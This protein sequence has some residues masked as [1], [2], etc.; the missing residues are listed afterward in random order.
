MKQK[1]I[2]AYLCAVM[3]LTMTG[4]GNMDEGQSVNAA[5]TD[6]QVEEDTGEDL[7]HQQKEAGESGGSPAGSADSSEDIV[8]EEP[9]DKSA[10]TSL[11]GIVVSIGDNSVAVN[12]MVSES[13]EDGEGEVTVVEASEGENITVYFSEDTQFEFKTVKNNGVNGDAD[14]ETR[15]GSFVDIREE[16]VLNMTGGY[17]GEDFYAEQVVIYEFV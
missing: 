4:C 14:V 17:Q 1:K 2:A 15:E 3:L 16:A 10:V 9:V 8:S 13:A 12:E 11:D 6:V 7:E 5:G